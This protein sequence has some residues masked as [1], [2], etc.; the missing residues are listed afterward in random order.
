MGDREPAD[1]RDI[2][3]TIEPASPHDRLAVFVRAMGLSPRETELVGHVVAGSDS[4][5]IARR[6]SLSP[7]TVQDH[8]KSV[9]AKT[10]SHSRRELV[11]MLHAG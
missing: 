7:H 11:A 6:L 9:F 4:L 2:A 8:L 10:G 1:R 3:V 5:D